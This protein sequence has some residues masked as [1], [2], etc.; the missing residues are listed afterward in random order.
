MRIPI[1]AV[2]VT[3][4]TALS[5]LSAG[6]LFWITFHVLGNT[7]RELYEDRGD[8][9]AELIAERIDPT[10]DPATLSR[11]IDQLGSIR[12]ATV[13]VLDG[14]GKMVAH[15][16][17]GSGVAEPG[18]PGGIDPIITT[19]LQGEELRIDKESLRFWRA[20]IDGVEYGLGLKQ[21]FRPAG[22]QLGLY[23]TNPEYYACPLTAG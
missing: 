13:F 23:V 1:F 15:P 8:V 18:P 16:L 3:A 20:E 4:F 6:I 5:I 9:F 22:W 2:L 12:G 7:I 19:V 17:I 10:L 14:D 11:E 21:L